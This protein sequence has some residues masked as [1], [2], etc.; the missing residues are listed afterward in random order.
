M[1]AIFV[2]TRRETSPEPRPC[3]PVRETCRTRQTAVV[4]QNITRMEVAPRRS[5]RVRNVSGSPSNGGRAH[6]GKPASPHPSSIKRNAT[7][8]TCKVSPSAVFKTWLLARENILW[9][10]PTHEELVALV[11]AAGARSASVALK[12]Y[13][14]NSRRASP[15]IC[16]RPALNETQLTSNFEHGR[17]CGEKA[18]HLTCSGTHS[19][20][21][22]LFYTPGCFQGFRCC[23]Q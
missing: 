5:L 9:P 7:S 2:H 23:C 18:A 8:A 3:A 10:Y 1:V 13:L 11:E 22:S 14:G 4:C 20:I 17:A 15:R 16:Y 6:V 19:G 12:N 21:N